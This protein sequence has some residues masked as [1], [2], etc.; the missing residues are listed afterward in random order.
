MRF[1]DLALTGARVAGTRSRLEKTALLAELVAGLRGEEIPV[2]VAYLAGE[3][4]QGRSGLGPALVR[5]LDGGPEPEAATLE[6]LE[7]DRCFDQL[8]ALSGAGSKAAR[9][10]R[11]NALLARATAPERDFLRRLMLGELRQGALEGVLLEGVARAGG[12]D[13]APLRRAAMLGGSLREVAT[14]AL[15]EGPRGLARFRLEVGRPLMPMLAQPAGGVEDALARLGGRAGLEWKL[16]GARVLLHK[17]GD[18]VRVFSRRLNDVTRAVPELVELGRT[19]PADTLVLDGE[20]LA[21]DRGGRPRP[22]QET[23]RRFGRKLEVEA[24][25]R[26]LPLTPWFF[27]LLLRDGVEWIDRPAD[28]RRGE[29]EAVVGAERCVPRLVTDDELAA[30]GFL[31]LAL[32]A[33]HEGLVAKGLDST[34]EAGRRGAQWLKLKPA[35]TLDLVVLAAEWGSGRRSGKLSNLHLGARGD[36][37]GE[38]VMRGKTFKGMTDEVLAWQTRE[39]LARETRRE[40]HVV[41]VRPELVVEV[42]FDGVQRSSQ[43]PGGMALRFARLVRYRPDKQAAE[44]DDVGAVRRAMQGH[45]GTA[46]HDPARHPD[47]PA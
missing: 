35:H 15:L 25:R 17:Q 26:E 20:V 1:E 23:M 4:R 38:L 29:L 45:A 7:V 37:P 27:D 28:E 31:E 24:V 8:A 41:H 47:E 10:E 9:V 22:F 5:S 21:L 42:A 44:A 12:L 32:A 3:L 46:P 16:D 18:R 39:L 6:L 43:Y 14:A 36:Q 33:G 34:Y 13:P 11:L 40:G 30:A 19:L 2:G